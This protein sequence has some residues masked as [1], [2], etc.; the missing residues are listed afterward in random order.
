L[1]RRHQLHAAAPEPIVTE[2]ADGS[3]RKVLRALMALT[4]DTP[5]HWAASL[6]QQIGVPL[7]ST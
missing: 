6:A 1:K 7:S 3:S 2:K 5:R 4:A